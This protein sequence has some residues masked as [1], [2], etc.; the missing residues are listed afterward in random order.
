M[1]RV[2][3]WLKMEIWGE[4]KRKERSKRKEAT[5]SCCKAKLKTCA[6][7][8]VP[9]S[10]SLFSHA[11]EQKA[12]HPFQP[13]FSAKHSRSTL[14]LSSSWG[15]VRQGRKQTHPNCKWHLLL[16]V[17]SSHRSMTLSE[18]PTAW[19]AAAR[20]GTSLPLVSILLLGNKGLMGEG[21]HW[22]VHQSHCNSHH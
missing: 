12:P 3:R 13:R 22:A 15:K 21:T 4:R 8:P 20:R 2:E 7:L 17:V 5:R 11:E 14:Q 9:P 1:Q 10:S 18:S 6:A 19:S 16:R